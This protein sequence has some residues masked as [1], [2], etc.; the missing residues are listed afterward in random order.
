[1]ALQKVCNKCSVAIGWYVLEQSARPLVSIKPDHVR[2]LA[3]LAQPKCYHLWP[4]KRQYQPRLAARGPRKSASAAATD[5][6]PHESGDVEEGEDLNI[7]Q[8]HVDGDEQDV[9]EAGDNE[10]IVLQAEALM[11]LMEM[12]AEHKDTPTAEATTATTTFDLPSQTPPSQPAEV[13]PEVPAHDASNGGS[14]SGAQS[15]HDVIMAVQHPTPEPEASQPEALLAT[16]PRVAGIRAFVEP[17][18]ACIVLP[19]GRIAYHVSKNSF[20]AVCTR[21]KNCNLSRIASARKRGTSARGFPLGGRPLGLLTAWLNDTDAATKED[22]KSNARLR[23]YGS[24]ARCAARAQVRA[25]VGGADLLSFERAKLS[26]EESEPE[27]LQGKD[28]DICSTCLV[29]RKEELFFLFRLHTKGIGWIVEATTPPQPSNKKDIGAGDMQ[30]LTSWDQEQLLGKLVDFASIAFTMP[31]KVK[32]VASVAGSSSAGTK[33]AKVVS[34]AAASKPAAVAPGKKCIC[35]LCGKHPEDRPSNNTRLHTTTQVNSGLEGVVLVWGEESWLD[36]REDKKWALSAQTGQ[37]SI[38]TGN[39]CEDCFCFHSQCFKHLPWESFLAQ[40]QQ[41]PDFQQTVNG[42]QKLFESKKPLAEKDEVMCCSSWS[43]EV[44]KPVILMTER[45]LRRKL[46]LTRL[47]RALTKSLPHLELPSEASGEIEVNF[48]FR[49]PDDGLKVGKLK[50]CLSSSHSKQQLSDTEIYWPGQAPAFMRLA[51]EEQQSCTGI[52]DLLQKD[53]SGHLHLQSVDEFL[54]ESGANGLDEGLGALG[55]GE[56][57]NECEVGEGGYQLIGAAAAASTAAAS[58]DGQFRTPAEK[59]QRRGNGAPSQGSRDALV[60]GFSGA[61]GEQTPTSDAGGNGVVPNSG[62]SVATGITEA[63]EFGAKFK[64]TSS[65]GPSVFSTGDNS[66]ETWKQ[67]I[68]LGKVLEG[69]VDG[70][71]VQ[72]LRRASERKLAKSQTRADGQLLAAFLALVT[73]A[74][75][76]SPN[77]LVSADESE[78][79]T[80][81]D[82]L[83][84][85]GVVPPE[86]LKYALVVKRVTRLVQEGKYKEMV[87]AASPFTDVEWDHAYPA[88]AALERTKR[89]STWKKLLFQDTLSPLISSGE[90]SAGRVLTLIKCCLEDMDAVDPV[91]IETSLASA[92]EEGQSVFRAIQELKD[93]SLDCT[94]ED[95]RGPKT[96]HKKEHKPT[97][98]VH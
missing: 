86:S 22:H 56:E 50:Y 4:I 7:D 97:V 70:R 17:A 60:R 37:K 84:S 19:H 75:T 31:P 65:C 69:I 32:R 88:L 27:A 82:K 83:K 79:G 93:P 94:C 76:L 80:T 64:R 47:P 25:A 35:A 61:V 49:P 45:D 20:E 92:L 13:I 10:L 66:L 55:E 48:V 6:T 1:M 51:T 15:S 72:G 24:A 95:K 28:H 85:E 44:E 23:S 62:A 34:V 8:S 14:A 33:K 29:A 53:V 81:L 73:K 43:F 3:W 96:F 63:D 91:E 39:Q 26:G 52:T 16:M 68:D 2:V 41:K 78:I 12:D 57:K 9:A 90:S 40:I 98:L 38:P 59:K 58:S 21:H 18:A 89:I 77:K 54:T 46:N 87:Q 67:R 74:H 71:S 5:L 11:M 36:L 30:T 42:A